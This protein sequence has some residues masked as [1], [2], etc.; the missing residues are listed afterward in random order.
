MD[1]TAYDCVLFEEFCVN[2]RHFALAAVLAT[3]T[4][5]ASDIASKKVFAI[6]AWPE[7][8]GP[9][10][11]GVAKDA[12]LPLNLD[13]S[14]VRWKT[15]IHD[16]GWSS[17][18][19]WGDQ[20]W[21]TTA[22]EDGMKMFA[23][24]VNRKSG[25]VIHDRLLIETAEPDFCHPQ[26]SYA[27]PTP[28]IEEGR[29][30]VHFGRYGT[31]CLDTESAETLWSRLDLECDHW[32]GPASSPILDDG[33]LFV[34]FDGYDVQYV[35]AFDAMTGDTVWRKKRDIDY[36]TDN[37]DLK[38]AYCTACMITVGG[39]KQLVLPSAIA[40]IAYDPDNGEMLWRVYHEGMN[41]SARPLFSNGLVFITN[42]M[43]KMVAVRP[44]SGDITDSH[45]AWR[46]SK[47]IAKKTSQVVRDGLFFMVSDG[48]V[49][50][51]RDVE[52]GEVLWQHRA[53]GEYAASPILVGQRLYFFDREGTYVVVKAAPEFE[54]LAKGT[55][56]DGY[57]A[58]PAV[59]GNELI[60]RS[61]THLYSL[62]VP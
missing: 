25:E 57:M 31:F 49:I 54:M 39:K 37:G 8:R 10:G 53:G 36:G 13:E 21:L 15:P 43:G 19:V 17:P 34:A 48:G 18:V 33:K 29:V 52:S 56:G 42:G 4:F 44:G 40:T 46:S 9:N 59:V 16:R 55:F 45:V 47:V 14:V 38:K 12:D 35:M 32:R 11:D 20:I 27:T 41:A 2:H 26:N 1:I 3:T 30:Y 22:T 62:A 5:I 50:S 51:C 24:C 58:S 7:Y 28:V 60:L 61:K 23:V 6:E